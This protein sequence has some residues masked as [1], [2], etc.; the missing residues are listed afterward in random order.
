MMIFLFILQITNLFTAQN[1]FKFRDKTF[2]QTDGLAMGAPT[3]S[4]LSEL[5]LH[6]LENTTIFDILCKFRILGYFRYVD[7][8]LIA[9]NQSHTDIEEVQSTFN[10][11]TPKLKFTLERETENE[12]NFLD[13]TITRTKNALSFDIYRKSTTTDIIIPYDS[14]HPSEQKLAAI[15]YYVNRMNTYDIVITNKQKELNTIKQIIHNN[16]YDTAIL[17]EVQR[18]RKNREKIKPTRK[19]SGQGSHTLEKK[20]G[21]LQN[22][23]RTQT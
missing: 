23:S 16:K 4:V 13:L 11:I 1:Y 3:S 5:Y 7:D 6:Y 14:C 18:S 22:C 17:N 20:R 15:R 12:L 2:L 21:T 8:I 9:Y 10:N 19:L